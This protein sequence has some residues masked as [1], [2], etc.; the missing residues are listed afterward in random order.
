MGIAEDYALWN[1]CLNNN[2]RFH[3]LPIILLRYRIHDNQTTLSNFTKIQSHTQQIIISNLRKYFHPAISTNNLLIFA[4]SKNL[5]I[6][7]IHLY[8]YT[9]Y[10]CMFDVEKKHNVKYNLF[11][12]RYFN[13]MLKSDS[14]INSIE[15]RFKS[16]FLKI[17]K[18]SG[19]KNS[20]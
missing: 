11:N 3:N 7:I 15:I 8:K 17:K 1:E 13:A 16:L 12:P 2:I 20:S 5:K 14:I 18:L 4:N 9:V 6:K 19:G 10:Y